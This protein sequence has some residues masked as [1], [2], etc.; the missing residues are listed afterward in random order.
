MTATTATTV[1]IEDPSGDMQ[2]VG[3]AYPD[4]RAFAERCILDDYVFP[5]GLDRDGHYTVTRR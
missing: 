4:P 1:M 3:M 2:C 5:D